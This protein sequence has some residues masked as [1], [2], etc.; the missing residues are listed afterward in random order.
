MT[1]ITLQKKSKA[2][3]GLYLLRFSAPESLQ[4]QYKIPGQYAIVRTDANQEKP[5]FFAVASAPT[6]DY[7][8]FL[9]K[10]APGSAAEMVALDEGQ[11]AECESVQGPGFSVSFRKGQPDIHMFSM[12]S[13][14]A[15]FRALIKFIEG[16]DSE[17]CNLHL[18]QAAFRLS[19]VPLLDEILEWEKK[20][21]ITLHLC[22]DEQQSGGEIPFFTGQVPDALEQ[23]E[24]NLKES[25]LLWIGSHEFSESLKAT[26]AKLGIDPD[27]LMT[28]Y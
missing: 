8:E 19:A 20:G 12:G 25:R 22:L 21:A 11:E 7:L 13:G 17:H 16:A 23:Y 28:N 6:E 3:D 2:G 24:D 9:I 26:V 15:P 14:F 4:G 18:W 1:R 27:L 10:E 5:A